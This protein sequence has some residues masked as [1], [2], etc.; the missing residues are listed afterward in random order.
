MPKLRS[1][2]L[3]AALAIAAACA[4]PP[5]LTPTRQV[6]TEGNGSNTDVVRTA[7]AGERMVI[8]A[9]PS[10]TYA[11]LRQAYALGLSATVALDD[12]AHGN[13]STTEMRVTHRL[14]GEPVSRYVSCGVGPAGVIADSWTVLLRLV[15]QVQPAGTDSSSIV[16]TVT[17]RAQDPA[18]STEPI[19]CQSTGALEKLVVDLTK[20]QLAN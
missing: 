3:L 2:R 16:T 12:P 17:A 8:A 10:A 11:A 20:R 9:S 1:S 7:D 6:L 4:A 15:S 14:A 5:Q 13:I 19:I 18:S